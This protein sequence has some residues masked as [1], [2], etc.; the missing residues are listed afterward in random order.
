MKSFF[1]TKAQ[2]VGFTFSISD[3]L[4]SDAGS[5]FVESLNFTPPQPNPRLVPVGLGV[6]FSLPEK[7]SGEISAVPAVRHASARFRPGDGRLTSAPTQSVHV[8]P[9]DVRYAEVCA[10]RRR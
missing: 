10:T 1:D 8:R 2:K 7:T 5:P 9:E 4:L 6:K 3:K